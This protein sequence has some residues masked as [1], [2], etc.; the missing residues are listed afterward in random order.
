MTE[1]LKEQNLLAVEAVA[2]R[3]AVYIGKRLLI[4]ECEVQRVIAKGCGK[5]VGDA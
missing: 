4:P 5:H 2:R 1:N 3:L